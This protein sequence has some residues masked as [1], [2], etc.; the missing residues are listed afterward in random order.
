MRLPENGA[1]E[2]EDRC[3]RVPMPSSSMARL[4][5]ALDSYVHTIAWAQ[6]SSGIF[7]KKLDQIT[8]LWILEFLTAD[9]LIRESVDRNK[10]FQNFLGVSTGYD[11]ATCIQAMTRASCR[12]NRCKLQR[13]IAG[14][15]WRPFGPYLRSWSSQPDN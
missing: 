15:S 10:A 11:E 4:L 3:H 8:I 13:T 12:G 14:V 2:K 9:M 7:C 1:K 6:I 5:I